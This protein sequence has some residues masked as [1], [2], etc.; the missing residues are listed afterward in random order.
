VKATILI[1]LGNPL[2]TDEGIGVRVIEAFGLRAAEFP[3]VEFAELG[4]A[5][6]RVLHALAGRRKAVLVDCA[7]MGQ[8]PGT[9]RRFL[10]DEVRSVK[11]LSGFSLH[12]GDLAD[13]ISLS[14]RLGEAPAQIVLFGVEPAEVG[15][16]ERLSS[17]L[18]GR[19]QEYL[20]AIAD[21][22]RAP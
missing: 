19:F 5:G 6:M 17:N 7:F 12:E 18:Q 21:E 1:G 9:L 20:R 10:P 4:T 13:I 22:L 2:M 14:R 11:R 16:G 3:A 15:A 8:P